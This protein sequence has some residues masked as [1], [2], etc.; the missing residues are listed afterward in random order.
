MVTLEQK[1]APVNSKWWQRLLAEVGISQNRLAQEIDMDKGGLSKR[2]GGFLD[3]KRREARE[4][5]KALYIDENEA[6]AELID[7]PQ[8]GR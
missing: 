5:A 7:K 2:L 4:I 3:F 1:N 8:K 6:M